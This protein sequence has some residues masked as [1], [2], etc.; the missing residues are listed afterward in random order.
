LEEAAKITDD[1]RKVVRKITGLDNSHLDSWWNKTAAGRNLG[2]FLKLSQQMAHL[3]LA[4]LSSITE[5]LILLTRDFSSDTTKDIGRALLS[6]TNNMFDRIGKTVSR[7]RGKATP[8]QKLSRL[9]VEKRD[10][11]YFNVGRFTDDE[12]FEL[13]QTGLALEQTVMERI[14]G[15]AGEALNGRVFK[16]FQNAFFKSNLLTQWTKAVQLASFTTGKR[17]VR[18]HAQALATNKTSLGGTLSAGRR[19]QFI[20]EL[21]EFGIREKDAI[22]W[23]RNSVTPD[24][25]INENFAK[26]LN[27]RGEMSLNEEA[28]FLL[29]CMPSISALSH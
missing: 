12:W 20:D 9:G 7:A 23:Y 17:I 21:S 1:F 25:K 6:E 15:L 22:R 14:E 18:Q 3:P 16:G 5:P 11:E 13:Y 2:D 4:T 27:N 28:I 24:G 19:Q 10:G 26:G 29:S 8:R